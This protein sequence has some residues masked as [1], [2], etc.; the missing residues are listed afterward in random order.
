MV[1][2][3]HFTKA[4]VLVGILV[5]FGI[6][7]FNKRIQ[8]SRLEV[9]QKYSQIILPPDYE[10]KQNTAGAGNYKTNIVL[11]F[12]FDPKNYEMFLLQN[13]INTAALGGYEPGSWVKSGPVIFRERIFDAHTSLSE[14][15]DTNQKM[16]EFHFKQK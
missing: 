3:I 6:I 10:I 9:F 5:L 1:L 15:I 8:H 2:N 4:L 16:F 12:Q 13:K 7:L 11:V 14:A